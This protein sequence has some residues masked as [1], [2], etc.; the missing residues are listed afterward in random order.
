MKRV[1]LL[2]ATMVICHCLNAQNIDYYYIIKEN[3]GDGIPKAN[4]CIESGKTNENGCFHITAKFDKAI[5]IKA[6]GYKDQKI[7]LKADVTNR[8][9]LTP[10]SGIKGGAKIPKLLK[11]EFEAPLYVVNGI[12]IATFKPSNYA[13]DMIREVTTT[14]KWNKITKKIFSDS[15][16]ESIDVI[17]RGVVMITTQQNIAFNTPNKEID[18]TI[19]VTD[20][21]GKPIKGASVYLREGYSNKSGELKFNAAPNQHAII[22]SNKYKQYPFTLTEQEEAEI[23]LEKKPK[24]AKESNRQQKVATFRS[25]GIEQFRKWVM[26]YA[27]SELLK[28]RTNHGT[29]VRAKFV[30]GTSGD[31]VSVEIVKQNNRRAAEVV[32]KTLYRSPKWSPAIQN[33]KAVK[34]TFYL[35]VNIPPYTS[36]EYNHN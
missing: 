12:Y 36:L 24:Q 27:N 25:G 6:D 22:I 23:T 32:K 30:V 28:C 14:N 31:I 9:I 21:E 33:G 18:Y 16:I 3:T 13:D 4:I 35:P 29:L 11:T 1:L 5:L 15:D 2:F 8:V 20:P 34:M 7:T 26:E 17:K 19:L 10:L